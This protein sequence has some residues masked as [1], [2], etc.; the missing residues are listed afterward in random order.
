MLKIDEIGSIIAESIVSFFAVDDNL[1][2][3][4]DLKDL[5]V[6]PTYEDEVVGDGF[7]DMRFVLTGTLATLKRNDAK[8]IIESLGGK[9]IG[10]VSSKTNVVVYGDEA[11][12]KL[13]KAQ[14]LNIPTWTEE[15]F[16]EEVKKHE[17]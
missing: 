11:G 13:S 5:G 14:E 2:L 16:L 10:S 4:S 6:N 1:Q 15:K 12:S 9:V 8:Q 3:L 7:K 17:E